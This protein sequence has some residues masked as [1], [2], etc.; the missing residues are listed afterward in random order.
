MGIK[1]SWLSKNGQN[2]GSIS[3]RN[4]H[5]TERQ[6]ALFQNYSIEEL[7]KQISRLAWLYAVG[8]IDDDTLQ[9]IISKNEKKE[10][11]ILQRNLPVPVCNRLV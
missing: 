2:G 3:T 8:V 10:I 5:T 1:I 6:I 11:V 4:S 9:E 7:D